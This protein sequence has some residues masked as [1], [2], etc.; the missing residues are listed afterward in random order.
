MKLTVLA[1]VLF[2]A[3]V[4][5][6]DKL[7]T[8]MTI[9]RSECTDINDTTVCHATAYMMIEKQRLWFRLW[10]THA[11]GQPKTNFC[12]PLA[13]KSTYQF[14]GVG[15]SY[16]KQCSPHTMPWRPIPVPSRTDQEFDVKVWCVKFKAQ[17]FNPIYNV[18]RDPA[19]DPFGRL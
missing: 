13:A 14:E 7:P 17:P 10:C 18:F 8:T 2:A 5:A 3:N 11:A 9:D 6:Q 15:D 4:A 16:P 12:G 19:P 1:F